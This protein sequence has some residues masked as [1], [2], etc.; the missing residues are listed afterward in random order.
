MIY[1]KPQLTLSV[2][3][4]LLD[5]GFHKFIIFFIHYIFM[6]L[7]ITFVKGNLL[8]LISW[9]IESRFKKKSQQIEMMDEKGVKNKL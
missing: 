6:Y 1:V 2:Y 7:E 5:S 8:D 4:N 9:L 3:I